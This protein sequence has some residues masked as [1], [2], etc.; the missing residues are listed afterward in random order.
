MLMPQESH[1]MRK[2]SIAIISRN[3]FLKASL[4]AIVNDLTRTATT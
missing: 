4:M 2:I 3:T 1:A